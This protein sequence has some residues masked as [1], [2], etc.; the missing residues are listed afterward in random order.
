MNRKHVFIEGEYYHLYNRGVDKR[1]TFIDVHDYHRFMLLLYF[2]NSVE[3]ANLQKV[4]REG[5][6]FT[7]FTDIFK[8]PK[9]EPLVAIGAWC[10]MPNHFHLLVKEISE[11]GI[12]KFMQKITT[13][14]TM[15]FNQKYERSGSLFQGRFKSEHSD[16]DNYLKYLFSYIHL[17]PV[18]LIAGE[19]KWKDVGIKN[20]DKAKKF[21]EKYEY[22]SFNNYTGNHSYE[23]IISKEEFPRYF[24]DTKEFME[25]ML[26]WLTFNAVKVL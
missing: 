22:S 18:K 5:S 21:L 24:A 15:Y 25:E 13:G 19:S 4:F 1:R 11:N 20:R 16:N 23:K 26:E 2:C 6:T 12:T 8:L 17:N 10:L 14:Y 3:P 9:G 7:R